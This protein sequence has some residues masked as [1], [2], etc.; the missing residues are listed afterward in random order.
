[1]G[2][3]NLILLLRAG[4][5]SNGRYWLKFEYH[6]LE[7]PTSIVNMS[8]LK[9]AV[10]NISTHISEDLFFSLMPSQVKSSLSLLAGSDSISLRHIFQN[11]ERLPVCVG[12]PP[13]LIPCMSHLI[14][15]CHFANGASELLGWVDPG[16]SDPGHEAGIIRKTTQSRVRG[17]E[18]QSWTPHSFTRRFPGNPFPSLGPRA[19]ICKM[20]SRFTWVWI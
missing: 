1:M 13:K 10:Q 11:S 6:L 17:S 4:W 20:S 15:L 19:L 12:C 18:F 2:F 3:N 5:C 7:N 14:A 8:F 16:D 9:A